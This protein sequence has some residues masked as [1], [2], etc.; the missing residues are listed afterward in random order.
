MPA[1]FLND[2]DIT[3]LRRGGIR[4][5]D[6]P[7]ITGDRFDGLTESFQAIQSVNDFH[8]IQTVLKQVLEQITSALSSI[9]KEQSL[10]QLSPKQLIA[11][12]IFF[13]VLA[14]F[15]VYLSIP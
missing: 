7:L 1:R 12:A 14:L 15:Q 6:I 13:G 2:A 11:V 3:S 9:W 5:T 8:S 10:Q 4:M